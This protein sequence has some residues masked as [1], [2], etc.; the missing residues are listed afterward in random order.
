[1][2]QFGVLGILGPRCEGFKVVRAVRI[3]RVLLMRIPCSR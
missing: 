3:F 1:M 2:L